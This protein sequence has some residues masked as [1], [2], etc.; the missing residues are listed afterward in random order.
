MPILGV[1]SLLLAT[2]FYVF[3][4]I[5]CFINL[6]VALSE[7][8]S[9]KL[10]SGQIVEEHPVI[11]QARNGDLIRVIRHVKGIGEKNIEN[12]YESSEVGALAVR[13]FRMTLQHKSIKG[14]K[15]VKKI[16]CST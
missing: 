11:T 7:Y 2:Y 5:L 9:E 13:A 14:H 10:T 1:V 3:L 16:T 4:Y 15:E 6:E 12:F 8:N